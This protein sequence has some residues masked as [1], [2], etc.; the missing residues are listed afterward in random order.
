M[1][2]MSY[3]Q[4]V[5]SGKVIIENL[6]KFSGQSVKI[7]IIPLEDKIF[8]TF[9]KHITSMR[10]SLKKYANPDLINREPLKGDWRDKMKTRLSLL[11]EPEEIIKPVEGIGVISI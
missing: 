3:I 9:P 6:E 10:G 7:I 5:E 11:V 4:R 2:A 8:D 1:E